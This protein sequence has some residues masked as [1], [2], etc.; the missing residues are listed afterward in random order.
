MIRPC[1]EIAIEHFFDKDYNPKHDVSLFLYKADI[2]NIKLLTNTLILNT[3]KPDKFYTNF[4]KQN[5]LPPTFYYQK[6]NDGGVRITQLDSQEVVNE[7]LLLELENAKKVQKITKKSILKSKR[8]QEIL[9]IATLF[10]NLA[11]AKVR[12]VKFEEFTTVLPFR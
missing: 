12:R 4:L 6:N 11:Q 10:K 2:T 7:R 5:F 9:E 8:K 3:N 1:D